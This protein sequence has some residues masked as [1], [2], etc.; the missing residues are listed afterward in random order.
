[1]K[2]AFVIV[3]IV[4]GLIGIAIVLPALAN[5]GRPGGLAH[6]A[7]G[8]LVLGILIVLVGG[9]ATIRGFCMRRA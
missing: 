6:D 9:S 3:G 5:Y 1:M 7:A 8:S 4:V 2:R